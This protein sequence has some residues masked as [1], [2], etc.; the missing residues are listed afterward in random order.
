MGL[1]PFVNQDGQ[2]VVRWHRLVI[3]WLFIIS[4]TM[5]GSCTMGFILTGDWRYGA[6]MGMVMGVFFSTWVT[7]QGF[8]TPI[9]KLP[10]DSAQVIVKRPQ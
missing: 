4:A 10:P 9:D 7:H 5:F 3:V 6:F 2:R 8:T 1:L